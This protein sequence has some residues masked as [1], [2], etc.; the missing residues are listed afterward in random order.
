MFGHLQQRD[1]DRSEGSNGVQYWVPPHPSSSIRRPEEDRIAQ[2][3]STELY[4][5]QELSLWHLDGKWP[6]SG[7]RGRVTTHTVDHPQKSRRGTRTSSTT[8]HHRAHHRD[9]GKDTSSPRKAQTH[10][11]D[12]FHGGMTRHN[13]RTAP[14]HYH[15]LWLWLPLLEEP[16][17]TRQDKTRLDG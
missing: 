10:Q 1:L 14:L 13:R 5:S 6:Q 3:P 15:G 17:Q 7:A 12:L 8:P 16:Q 4:E 11:Q 9:G 2:R